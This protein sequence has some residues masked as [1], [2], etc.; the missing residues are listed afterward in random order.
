M[1]SLPKAIENPIVEGQAS[2]I[3]LEAYS[4]PISGYQIAKRIYGVEKY[5]PTSK[6][7]TWLKYFRKCKLITE[8]EGGVISNAEPVLDEITQVLEEL[9]H[10]LTASERGLVFHLI[11]SRGFRALVGV[12]D[13]GGSRY[14]VVQVVGMILGQ[15]AAV[16]P[17]GLKSAP[18]ILA[19]YRDL[20][21]EAKEKLEVE[22]WS[23]V[24]EDWPRIRTLFL[25]L[26][27]RN[28]ADLESEAV[29][30][31]LRLMSIPDRTL[32]KLSLL[33]PYESLRPLLETLGGIDLGKYLR[34]GEP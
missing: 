29:T 4:G 1:R 9:G 16:L 19:S 3:F 20:P 22:W 31:A 14:N 17:R 34:G 21:G 27:A 33:S 26:G 32:R 5:P 15:V 10:P 2:R 11:D 6:V 25:S 24:Q 23:E 28:L 7:Y 13:F 30:L 18:D 8:V 12:L